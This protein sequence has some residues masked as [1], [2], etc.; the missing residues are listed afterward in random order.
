MAETDAENLLL[1][2]IELLTKRAKLDDPIS[3]CK[4]VV[5]AT[6]DDKTVVAIEILVVGEVA[7][8]DSEEIPLLA[9]VAESGDE[10]VEVAA[11]SFLHELGVARGE[12]QS[13]P[14][15]LLVLL[16]HHHC[17]FFLILGEKEVNFIII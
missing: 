11:V 13:E 4:R 9:F 16:L 6:T 17:F 7:V 14:L 1:H 5:R 12:K 3:V 10:Y 8:D 2:L 15:R